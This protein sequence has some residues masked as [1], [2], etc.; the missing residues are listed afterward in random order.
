MSGEGGGGGG[1]LAFPDCR[2]SSYPEHKGLG[3]RVGALQ[4][5][6]V[7]TARCYGQVPADL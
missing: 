5:S 7:S 1:E 4:F 6:V 2:W 3:V